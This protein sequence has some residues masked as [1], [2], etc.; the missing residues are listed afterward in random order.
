[1]PSH[2]LT[3]CGLEEL[4]LH[5]AAGVTHV[6]SILDPSWPEPAEFDLWDAHDR[7]VL[8]F[9]D[10]IDEGPGWRPP[11]AEHVAAILRFGRGLPRDRQLHLLVHCHMGVSRST[12]AAI[13]LLAQHEPARD[14]DDIVAQIVRRR[15]QAWP[16]I[17]IIEAGDEQLDRGGVLVE[18]VRRHYRAVVAVDPDYARELRAGGRGR[19]VDG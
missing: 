11:E 10:V 8:R 2:I 16:N 17:R 19:E 4:A 18:A 15:P 12:A 9:H 14:A 6:V 5:R 7:L 13:L 1:M 3:I